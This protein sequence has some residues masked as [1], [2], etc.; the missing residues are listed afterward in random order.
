MKRDLEV[1]KLRG[2]GM[3]LLVKYSD[4][5]DT[6]HKITYIGLLKTE[7]LIDMD[8]RSYGD[9]IAYFLNLII[10]ILTSYED[11]MSKEDQEEFED[12]C[13]RSLAL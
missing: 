1:N 11:K 13:T 3:D 6:D 8:S 9:D 4:L 7:K 2:I 12:V 10:E 5:L